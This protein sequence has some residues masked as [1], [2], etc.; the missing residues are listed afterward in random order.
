MEHLS[1]ERISME[2]RLEMIRENYGAVSM[3]ESGVITVCSYTW[4]LSIKASSALEIMTL[5]D[6]RK[7]LRIVKHQL[8]P[9]YYLEYLKLWEL[10]IAAKI[11]SFESMAAEIP[12]RSRY[13]KIISRFRKM[14]DIVNKE[15]EKLPAYVFEE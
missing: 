11:S 7:M 2:Q 15:K 14:L 13:D 8:D 6:F 5:P 10:E 1:R 9:D 12:R 4:Q 3:D